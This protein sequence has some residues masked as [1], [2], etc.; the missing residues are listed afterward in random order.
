MSF[1]FERILDERTALAFS[2]ALKLFYECETF[3][4]TRYGAPRGI[5]SCSRRF[6]DQIA[7]R[8]DERDAK[9]DDDRYLWKDVFHNF[10]GCHKIHISKC[11]DQISYKHSRF[12]ILNKFFLWSLGI[13]CGQ[14]I[15]DDIFF[16]IFIYNF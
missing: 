10:H 5:G 2:P 15:S 11:Y 9:C 14:I 4:R 6:D 7:W 3:E 12:F 16:C 8:F 13:N 1:H